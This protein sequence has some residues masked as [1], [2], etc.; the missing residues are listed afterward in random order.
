[1]SIASRGV[2][3]Q[4][5]AIASENTPEYVAYLLLGHVAAI[6]GFVLPLGPGNEKAPKDRK[7]LLD[8]YAECLRAVTWPRSGA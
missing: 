3:S 6:E 7:W 4:A 5:S 2:A 1:M 8:A